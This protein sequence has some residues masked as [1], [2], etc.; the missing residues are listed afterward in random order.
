M[1]HTH[2]KFEKVTVDETVK[3]H[4]E[5]VV[6]ACQKEHHGKF[7]HPQIHAAFAKKSGHHDWLYWVQV[8]T[9]HFGDFAEWTVVF[10][11]KEH[12]A[13]LDKIHMGFHTFF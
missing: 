3:G 10:E 6:P 13:V 5:L 7:E 1:P 8:K 11:I 2:D 12:K 9:G 4:F